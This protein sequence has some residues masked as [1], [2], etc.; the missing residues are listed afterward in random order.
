MVSRFK[1]F[2]FAERN[3]IL[4]SLPFELEEEIPFDPSTAIFDAQIV[5]YVGPTAEVMA[6]AAP[7]TEVVRL[8]NLMQDCMME[9]QSITAEGIAFA[10]LFTN[11]QDA[12]PI[13]PEQPPQLEDQPPEV[14]NLK[15]YINIGSTR[16][17][18]VAMNDGQLVGVRSILWGAQVLVEALQKKYEITA[19][20]A[21]RELE[22]KSFILPYRE[23]ASIDQITFSETI[24]IPCREL[25]RELR[26]TLLE[27]SAEFNGHVTDVFLTG[28][29]S[30]IVNLNAFLTTQLDAP[31][32]IIDAFDP[33]KY[34]IRFDI[35]AEF[36]S[37]F[38]IAFGLALEGI[39]KPR[40]P[41]VTFL[42]GALAKQNKFF[43]N[44]WDRWGNLV[45]VGAAALVI[46]FV[47]A[48]LRE[49]F[50]LN[51]ADRTQEALK[52]QAKAIAKLS[53]TKSTDANI[54]KFIRE[55][56]K[57]ALD[58]KMLGSLSSMTSAIEIMKKIS[59]A[60]PPKNAISLDVKKFNVQD[61]TVQIEGLAKD[62]KEVGL[63][64]TA[65]NSL[66]TDGKIKIEA[67]TLT[68]A[69]GKVPFSISFSMSR[70]IQKP[71]KAE[72]EK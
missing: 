39:K 21:Q 56:K 38:N 16:T 5:R 3:K 31:V 1:T 19:I 42:R 66:T 36:I 72:S 15:I 69:P 37:T 67:S 60:M 24:A 59:D 9:P 64:Q 4:K 25:A 68:A 57:K 33:F 6:C 30:Q 7:M 12:P 29:G 62:E 55:E 40:N 35:D 2:P 28:G 53:S 18:L 17:L 45:Q 51:L 58:M 41:S 61:E 10:N 43:K 11:W 71:T 48:N 13:V 14:R 46:L 49:G 63:I 20:E 23:G 27:L 65:L 34:L 26:L 8:N 32:N 70:G 22:G 44:L 50:S 54:K 52:V 47:Y